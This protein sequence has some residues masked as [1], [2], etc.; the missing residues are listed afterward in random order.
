MEGN[1][2]NCSKKDLRAV[3]DALEVLSGKWKL[4]ILIAI[5]SGNKRFKEITREIDGIS[6]RM[7]SKELK[8]LEAHSLVKRNVFD[9]FP[10]VVEYS[11]T[12]HTNSLETVINSLKDWGHLH[13]EKVIGIQNNSLI[14]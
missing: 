5:L 1:T 6:D 12:D 13:R 10:P 7:L 2:S 9:T 3:R 4:Q 11:G 14:N 8:E